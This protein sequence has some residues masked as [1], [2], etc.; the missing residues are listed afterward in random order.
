[1]TKMNDVPPCFATV[2]RGWW[3]RTNT[4]TRNGGSSPHHPFATRIVFPRALAAAEHAPAHEDR[5]RGVERFAHHLVVRVPLSSRHSV[6]FAP[7]RKSEDPLMKSFATVAERLL[8]CPVLP[9]D[10]AI[11]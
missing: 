2:S 5:S 11:Q 3:V 1:M 4:G 10:E 7:A 9:G 6:A 8:Y